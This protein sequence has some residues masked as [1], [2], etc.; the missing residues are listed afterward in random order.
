MRRLALFLTACAVM[1]AQS[2][3]AKK[4]PERAKEVAKPVT[5]ATPNETGSPTKTVAYSE[6]DVVTLKTKLRYTT[7]I[8]L[9]KNEQILEVTCGDKELWVVNGGQNMAY[10]KP[11]KS[12]AHT[13]S[14]SS[15]R[16]GT[17]IRFYW[18][19]SRTIPKPSR[20]SRCS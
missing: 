14:T 9:P 10:I 12:G 13:T 15:R 19:K 16:V 11:A 7:L 6:K 2:N 18:Q 20:T 3:A 4:P 1:A 5:S 17:F 8:V